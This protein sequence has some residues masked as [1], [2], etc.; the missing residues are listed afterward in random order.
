[1]MSGRQAAGRGCVCQLRQ[2]CAL[3][4]FTAEN[5]TDDRVQLPDELRREAQ[6][7][8]DLLISLNRKK[9]LKSVS[10]TTRVFCKAD[11]CDCHPML[12]FVQTC[13]SVCS[14]CGQGCELK[15]CGRSGCFVLFFCFVLISSSTLCCIFCMQSTLLLFYLL[16]FLNVSCIII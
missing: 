1:M 16:L 8:K 3:W 6:T 14:T 11:F 10:A 7:I 2:L 13:E 4:D 9:K 15:C 5:K 12:N